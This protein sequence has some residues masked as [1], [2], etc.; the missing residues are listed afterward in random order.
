[1]NENKNWTT[2]LCSFNFR[3]FQSR[4][5]LAL[6]FEFLVGKSVCL[7]IVVLKL[8]LNFFFYQVH[9]LERFLNMT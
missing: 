1:M 8:E 6:E 3:C 2:S 7:P 4:Q 5:K 9:S